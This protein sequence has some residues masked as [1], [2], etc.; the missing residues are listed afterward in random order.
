MLHTD[1][2][3]RLKFLT[4][5]DHTGRVGG[6]VE[7]ECLGFVRNCSFQLLC[8]NLKVLLLC[9]SY[10]HWLCTCLLYHFA[11]GQPI[12]RRNH[13]LIT[14]V[15]QHHQRDID[16]MLCTRSHNNL[17]RFI[18]QPAIL[19]QTEACRFLQFHHTGCRSIL[20]Q[21]SF[22]RGDA[23]LLDMLGRREIRFARAKSNNIDACGLHFLE[24]TINYKR[25][26]RL[27]LR[28]N[29]RNRLELL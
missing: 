12:G 3:N 14:G 24:H 1:I 13:N 21:I 28:R 7:H 23:R 22:N 16:C 8:R 10:N 19:L 15:T 20:G 18:L 29:R 11:V 9:C 2:C 26:R 25:G 17:V 5:I 4:G 6:R 27:Y